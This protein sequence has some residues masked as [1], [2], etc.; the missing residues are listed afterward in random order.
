MNSSTCPVC[1]SSQ[2]SPLK[3]VNG[4]QYYECNEC[5]VIF[6]NPDLLGQMDQGFSLI[7]YKDSYW[8]DELKAARERSWGVALA[9][10]AELFLYARIPVRKFIDIGS[11]PGYLLDAINYQLPSSADVFYAS[12]LFPP[13]AEHCT[14]SLNYHRGS[15]LDLD[16][17]FDAGSCIEV[18][19]HITPVMLK[20]MM[21]E[22]AIKSRP[23]SIYIFNTG[24]AEYIK[25]EDINY[26]D[27]LVRGHVMGWS[28]KALQ[29]LLEPTGFKILAIPGKTWA[30]IAEFQPDH[31]FAGQLQDRIWQALPEN[32]QTLKDKK[33]GDLLFVLGLET[34]RAYT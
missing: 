22:L 19:E 12:E 33:T 13:P 27:P 11:G 2:T 32:T 7:D 9:R 16:F 15:F 26:L 23:G 4:Y 3:Y 5:E 21:T 34:A 25:N 17:H 14:K 6:I 18:I 8:K 31:D 30:F 1:Y 10:V 24:L 29:L 20:T 28:I